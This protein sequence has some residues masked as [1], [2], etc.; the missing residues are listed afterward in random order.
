MPEYPV[1]PNFR[2][3]SCSQSEVFIARETDDAFIF[4]C[5]TCRGV[6]VWPKKNKED[7]GR[8]EAYLKM[9]AAREAQ[10][11][12]EGSRKAFSFGGD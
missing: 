10:E 1:C 9:R 5:R 11:R 12:H 7:A 3:G 6:N 4:G 2:E 8:Y